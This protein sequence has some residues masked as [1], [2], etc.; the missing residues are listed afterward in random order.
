MNGSYRWMVVKMITLKITKRSDFE[1]G[2]KK[3]NCERERDGKNLCP[4][5]EGKEWTT[6]A[7]GKRRGKKLKGKG[8]RS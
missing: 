6:R 4:I 3:K 7:E 8:K 1:I 2:I 5:A